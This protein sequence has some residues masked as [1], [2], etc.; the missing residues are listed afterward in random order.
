MGTLMTVII[1]TVSSDGSMTGELERIA[2]SFNMSY[3]NS[4]FIEVLR[5]TTTNLS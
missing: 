4:I 5:K 2:S 3:Y 1:E